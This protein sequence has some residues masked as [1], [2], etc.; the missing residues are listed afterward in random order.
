MLGSTYAVPWPP[1]YESMVNAMG[2][3]NIDVSMIRSV[4]E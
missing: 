3:V 1:F 2:S 4:P